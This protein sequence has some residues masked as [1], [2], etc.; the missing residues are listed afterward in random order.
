MFRDEITHNRLTRSALATFGLAAILLVPMLLPYVPTYAAVSK[1]DS[2][3]F[4]L[5][6]TPIAPKLPAD[7]G[8]Y[9][10]LIQLQ[11]TSDDKPIAAPFDL[12]IGIISS[13]PSVLVG[14]EKV[15][16]K[17]GESLIKA[18][19]ATTKKA[20]EVSIS[21]QAE[22]IES[23][24]V[25]IN[26]LKLD[27]QEPTK[28]VIYA[29]PV[30]FIP[31]PKFEGT[32]YV[33]L[34]NSQNVPAVTPNSITVTLSSSKPEIGTL[35]SYVTIPGGQSGAVVKF[36]P[37]YE[38]GTTKIS[39]SST[40]LS[41][42][43]LDVKTD[44]P[45]ASKLVVE[46]GPPQIPSSTGYNTIMTVQLQDE[47][48]VPVKA[49]RSL[50]VLLK[51]SENNVAEVPAS[52]TIEP[53]QSYAKVLVRSKGGIGDTIITATA[54]G[55]DPGI[56]TLTTV[57]LT[58]E[59]NADER[60][61]K[62]YSVPSKLPP[63][64]SEHSAIII[65]LTDLQGRP[66]TA[67]KT[68]YERVVLST[69][70]SKIG[71]VSGGYITHGTYAEATFKTTFV[72]GET[73]ITAS[74]TGYAPAQLDLEVA[75]SAPAELKLTQVPAIVDANSAERDYLV[76][77]LVDREG[78][79]V[80]APQE[81]IVYLASSTEEI[82]TVQASTT[83]PA[84]AAYTMVRT[85]TTDKAGESTITATASDLASANLQFKTIG[86]AGT[87][88]QYELGLYTVPMLAANG[89]E[90]EA[91]FIQL[92]DQTGN[93]AIAES[94]VI[95]SLSSS[96]LFA[97]KVQSE[98]V[99]PE[100]STFAIAKFMAGT[101]EDSDLKISASSPGFKSVE[102]DMET[103][104]QPLSVKI[105]NTLPKQASFG[106]EI[107]IE[108]EVMAGPFPAKGATVEF[109]GPQ[110]DPT[111]AVTDDNG[112]SEGVYVAAKPGT[113]MIQVKASQPGFKDAIAKGSVSFSQT[114]D[115]AVKAVSEGG[116]EIA[117]QF[118]IGGQ[119]SAA[120]NV[121]SKEG[122]AARLDNV[123]WGTYRITAPD[124]FT[125]SSG[126][127]KF[128]SWSDGATNN[129]RLIEV[130]TDTEIKAIYSAQFMVQV[131]SDYGQT[132]GSGYYKEGDIAVISIDTLSVGSGLT[133]KTFA[134]W[135]GDFRSEAPGAQVKVDGPKEIKAVWQDNFL[136]MG[137]IIGAAAAG[138]I[139]AYAKVIKPRREAVQKSRA[140][141]LDWYKS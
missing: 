116:T 65:Q 64:N 39:A 46:F 109:G 61:I 62:L 15:T 87:I 6:I 48:E 127:F 12:E 84:G 89:Q 55:L 129:P 8:K 82:A 56:A 37:K 97:G 29:A 66:W 106:E 22:G 78:K 86:Y 16:L 98:A 110:S 2:A 131:S 88:S 137:L 120:K 74:S 114:V 121:N 71:T 122:S 126:K 52:V 128:V 85:K 9:Y 3:E 53:G 96:S 30:S 115:L 13:D 67:G 42:A 136:K 60:L 70:E 20:G 113:N 27:S 23:D 72:T 125:S 54:S 103:A 44:G 49:A 7:G 68:S 94:D 92:Q 107:F 40:G 93:P 118:K 18:E 21:A 1:L 102:A 99:I 24:S 57:E 58:P 41:P 34:L 140:P 95:V 108:V 104:L 119:N 11:T 117:A 123:K 28:L 4:Q 45:V 17:E 47:D 90:Q 124:E 38:I 51:S 26:T 105:L 130:I 138:G 133:D 139:I 36:A 83:I 5:D 134:G 69:S 10:A 77:N 132:T 81:V 135:S 73:V 100:G 59:G 111:Y 91:V 63:D 33:Q 112:N 76:L 75:G 14:Q 31:D 25:T 101:E 141:D 80:V 79:P 50:L 19:L 32:L 35:P 43:Q